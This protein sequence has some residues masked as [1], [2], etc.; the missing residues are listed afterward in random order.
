MTFTYFIACFLAGGVSLRSRYALQDMLSEDN[1]G[2]IRT[3]LATIFVFTLGCEAAG[4][5]LIYSQ[6]E[7]E[8]AP[9]IGQL[10]AAGSTSVAA[11]GNAGAPITAAQ[12]SDALAAAASAGIPPDE[13]VF[14][15]VFHAVTAF[16]NAGFSTLN[17]N[18]A[19]NALRGRTSIVLTL[20]ALVFAGG[21][22]F[23]VVKNCWQ[24]YTA[25]LRRLFSRCA[26][27]PP[28]LES[29]TRLVLTVTLSLCVA[30]TIAIYVTE[31]LLP[32][33][34]AQ[35][36]AD[37]TA[38]AAG[39]P[40]P[41]WLAAIIDAFASRTAGFTA[42]TGWLFADSTAMLVMFLM[43]V[44][45]GPSST[46]GG[47]KTTTLGVAILALRRIVLGRSDIEA[48]GRRLDDGVAHRALATILL[49]LV[50]TL[51]VSLL[52]CV[53][54]PKLRTL[55]L[56]FESVSA[57][58]TCGMSRGVTAQLHTPAKLVL[59]VTM[60]IGRVGV[61]TTLLALIKHR[62]PT[63]YRFPQGNVIIN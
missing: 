50:F 40:H 27:V 22:G 30:G 28:R 57:A 37:G 47:I 25:T 19:D 34:G 1:L 53:L 17:G 26:P 20:V 7:M 10:F 18:L 36:A 60:F 48:F 5:A 12:A 56:V 23:P 43:F 39:S 35:L 38:I 15:S 11:A 4:A 62:D 6:L 24:H 45:G 2:Q 42:S 46:A 63:G 55:D 14:F 54:E 41:P 16:C 52:L 3:V 59:V 61:L 49:A 33:A 21:L 9:L 44:G 13:R 29:N 58:S 51:C 8:S 31:N 32:S